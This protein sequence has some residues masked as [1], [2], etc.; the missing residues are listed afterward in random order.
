VILHRASRTTAVIKSLGLGGG[1]DLCGDVD[2]TV[3]AAKEL[4]GHIK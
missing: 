3:G 1:L 4:T 2:D